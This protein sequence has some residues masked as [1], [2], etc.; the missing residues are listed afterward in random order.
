MR[1]IKHSSFSSSAFS[2][3]LPARIAGL[4]AIVLATLSLTNVACGADN[5]APT[6]AAA[7]K[8]QQA[9]AAPVSKGPTDPNESSPNVSGLPDD[10]DPKFQEKL[11]QMLTRSDASIKLLRIQITQNQS[12]PFLATLYLQLGDLLQQKS[13]VL[14]YLQMEHDKNTD[15]KVQETKK[16]SP[17]VTTERDAIAIYQQILKEFPKFDRTEKVMYRLALALKSID[18]SA[19]FVDISEKLVK[20][21]PTSKESVQVRLLLG[22]YFYDQHDYNQALLHL[23][24]IEDSTYAYERNAARYRIGL[25]EIV[26]EKHADALKHFE[27]VALDPDLK[28]DDNPNEISLKSKASKN[29]VKREALIDSIRAY[30][31]VYK[32]N[33]DPVAYYSRVAPTEVLFQETIEKLAYRYIFLKNYSFAIKLLRTLSERTADAQKIMNIYHDVLL[34]IPLEDRTGLPV[35]EIQFVLEKYDY[36]ATHYTLSPELTHKSYEFFETQLRELATHSHDLAKKEADGPMRTEHFERARRFYILYLGFFRHDPHSVKIATNLADVY[37]NQHNYLE[38]GSYYL[39]TFAGEFGNATQKEALIQNAILALQK[40]AEYEFY[41]Q[42]RAKGLLVKAIRTYQAFDKK[43]NNDPALVF[44]LAKTYYEQGYYDHALEDLY[45]FMKRFPTSAETTSAAELILNYFNI[46]SD[47]KGLVTWSQKMLA[48]NIPNQALKVRLADVRSKAL[49]KRLDEQ[50]K[51]Q[52]GYDIFSQG[53]SYLQSALSSGDASLRSAAFEQALARSR[54]EKDIETFLTAA[55]LMAKA[56]KEPKK[57]SDLLSSMADE[58]VAIT[59]FYQAL[60]IWSKTVDDKAVPQA[61]RVQVFEKMV[62]LSLMLKDLQKLTELSENPLFATLAPETAKAF[63]QFIVSLLDAPVELP[64]RLVRL[65]IARAGSGADANDTWLALYRAQFRMTPAT[66]QAVV[67]KAQE[68]CR[69]SLVS[70]L[71]KWVSFSHLQSEIARFSDSLKTTPTTLASVEPSA[72]KL[73]GLLELIKGYQGSGEPQLDIMITIG[74]GEVYQAFADFLLRTAQANKEVAPILTQKASESAKSA[75]DSKDQ[76]R[77]IINSAH[78]K[79]EINQPCYTGTMPTLAQALSWPKLSPLKATGSDPSKKDIVD[80]QKKLF[81]SHTD[82]K[83]YFDIGENYLS[84]GYLNHAAATAVYASST[85][86]QNA[87][88]FN[89]I[90]GCALL[91]MGLSNEAQFYLNKA[92]YINGLKTKCLAENKAQYGK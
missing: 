74:A 13:T 56:E 65:V 17:V 25:I 26:Q 3:T 1:I 67:Q 87:D 83:T 21:Y 64:D 34:M 32:V 37:F 30:T 71:C 59:R 69:D 50:V 55:G 28:E 12:A 52:K 62:K 14:Y 16:F 41:E 75:K 89:A 88:E 86:A 81:V 49:L 70:P 23:R 22:Q 78:L 19:A 45:Q 24:A 54:S 8:P 68:K 53:K 85:F 5:P 63:D 39:R 40:P 92:S 76:C 91:H 61:T 73:N 80:Q 38:S 10:S 60:K 82:W 27:Q 18:E 43:K 9:A 47:F 35:D 57:R 48:L 31:E 33:P 2:F 29:N 20:A 44:S 6:P 46:R 51:T 84:Q 58:T 11:N 42:L 72:V 66:R 15:L 7:A 90:L 77:T 79:T 4:A 36:W